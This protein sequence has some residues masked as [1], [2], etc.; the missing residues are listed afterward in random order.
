MPG[1]EVLCDEESFAEVSAGWNESGLGFFFKVNHP[2]ERVFYPEITKGDSIEVFID[3][4]DVKTSGY[5]TR[6][7]HYFFFLP[8][9]IDGI[10][11]GEA[12]HFRTDDQHE[13]CDFELLQV[14]AQRKN[15]GYELQAWIPKK[16]LVGYDPEQFQRMGFTYRINRNYWASQHFS[17]ISDDYRLEEQ[18]SLWSQL[19][20]VK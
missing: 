2:I 19:R 5:N 17:V 16:C 10:R 14:N 3:T 13:L 15:R 1:T 9:S 6:F 11:A 12:T 18:P 4:R 7:C 8:E 20:F